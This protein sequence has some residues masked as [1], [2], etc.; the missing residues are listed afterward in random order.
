MADRSAQQRL[1]QRWQQQDDDELLVE[2]EW[3]A[4]QI[5]Q[6]VDRDARAAMEAQLNMAGG[7]TDE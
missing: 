7:H 5:A 2:T 1:L 4:G 3:I 6:A